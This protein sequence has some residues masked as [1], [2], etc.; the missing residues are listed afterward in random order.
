MSS[1]SR[2]VSVMPNVFDPNCGSRRLLTLLAHKWS[3]LVVYALVDGVHRHAELRHRLGGISQKM[4]TQ[5]LRTLERNGL[6]CREIFVVVPPHVEYSL[7][8]LGRSLAPVLAALCEWSQ[9]HLSALPNI[10]DRGTAHSA[11]ADVRPRRPAASKARKP[12]TTPIV[13][14]C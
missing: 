2:A 6:V 14:S 12:P 4:L 3:V 13:D 9:D 8:D 5:T 7:T 10:Q 11:D 1:R